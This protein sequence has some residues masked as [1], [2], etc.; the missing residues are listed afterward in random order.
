MTIIHTSFPTLPPFID[1]IGRTRV[2]KELCPPADGPLDRGY[3]RAG[4]AFAVE[5]SS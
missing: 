1:G 2:P 3:D 5:F 4:F